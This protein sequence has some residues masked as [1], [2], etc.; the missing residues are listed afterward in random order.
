MNTTQPPQYTTL[1]L[2]IKNRNAFNA[3][4]RYGM[5]RKSPASNLVN[6]EIGPKRLKNQPGRGQGGAV[7]R[8]IGCIQQTP[9]FRPPVVVLVDHSLSELRSLSR[10]VIIAYV[11]QRKTCEIKFRFSKSEQSSLRALQALMSNTS[12]TS[13]LVLESF[14]GNFFFF[15]LPCIL[16]QVSKYCGLV[17]PKNGHEKEKEEPGNS[18]IINFATEALV[19]HVTI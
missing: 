11:R 13:T 18:L 2:A 10:L 16:S 7:T 5:C 3:N 8:S 19:S 1:I 17:R 4:G 14:P 12:D 9:E 15:A 6:I